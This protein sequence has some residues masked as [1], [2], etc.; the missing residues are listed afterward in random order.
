MSIY[1]VREVLGTKK[2]H[3]H[4]EARGLNAISVTMTQLSPLAVPTKRQI[5][6]QFYA[7]ALPAFMV[8]YPSL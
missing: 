4:L 7:N 3:K 8:L 6:Y 1:T 5:A 2:P